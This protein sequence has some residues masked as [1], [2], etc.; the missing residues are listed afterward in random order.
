MS[1]LIEIDPQVELI[2][3]EDG[4]EFG[5]Y[6]FDILPPIK[7]SK[8]NEDTKETSEEMQNVPLD[9]NNL[10]NF[11]QLQLDNPFCKNIIKQINKGNVIERQPYFLE[12]Y[13]LHRI[14]KEQDSQYESVVI[15]ST[16]IP[17]ILQATHDLLGHNGIG[18]TDAIL[19]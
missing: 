3:E 6:A 5:Y 12:D 14:I 19:K 1:R 11:I 18:R 2:L 16:L 17:Q 9:V 15:P 8:I 13:I 4:F 10:E 7:V